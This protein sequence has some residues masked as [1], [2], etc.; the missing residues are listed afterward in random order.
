MT[1]SQSGHWLVPFTC[2]EELYKQQPDA[3]NGKPR[4]VA[5]F[6]STSASSSSPAQPGLPAVPTLEV[7]TAETRARGVTFNPVVELQDMYDDDDNSSRAQGV[8]T[9]PRVAVYDLDAKDVPTDDEGTE[10]EP[11]QV[12]LAARD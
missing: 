2:L 12:T 9:D 1:L 7:A 11:R 4:T 3:K 6:P 5:S 10:R 8:Q